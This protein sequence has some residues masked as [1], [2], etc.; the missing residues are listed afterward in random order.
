[1]IK[2]FE[3]IQ[4]YYGVPACIGRGVTVSGRPGVIAEDKGHYIGVLFDT[5]K[6]TEIMP[7]HPTSE[8]VYGEIRPVRPMTR[9]QKRYRE[10]LRLEIDIPFGDYLKM[11]SKPREPAGGPSWI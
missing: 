1:M 11:I 7:C 5:D 6:P 8:V 3:Y 10:F 9:S 4:N 2:A